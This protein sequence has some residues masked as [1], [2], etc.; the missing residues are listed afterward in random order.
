VHAKFVT[1]R[2]R[3]RVGR[4]EECLVEGVSEESELLLQGRCW[5]QAPEIDGTLYITA[6]TAVAGE[7][8]RV[9]LTDAYE[10][11]LFGEIVDS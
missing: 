3:G 2:N 8:H 1:N 9:K 10:F 7:I 6:G 11:D 4:V 5:D